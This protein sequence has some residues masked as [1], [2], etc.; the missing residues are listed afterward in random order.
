MNFD[1]WLRAFAAEL[2]QRRVATDAA[3]HVVAEAATHLREGGGDPWQV[4][5]PPQAYAAAIVESIGTAP[6]TSAGT[7]GAPCSPGTSPAVRARS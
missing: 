2:H 7:P 3:R 4:F 1:D 5:G 6:G